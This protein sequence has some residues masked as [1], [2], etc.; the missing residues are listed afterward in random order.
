[1]KSRLTKLLSASGE[2]K[3]PLYTLLTTAF[4]A[5]KTGN[6]YQNKLLG[7]KSDPKP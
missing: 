4:S 3:P 7:R 5:I 2:A 6:E 1:M